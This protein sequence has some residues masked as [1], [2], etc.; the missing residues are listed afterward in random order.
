M[1]RMLAGDEDGGF[2]ADFTN[3]VGAV[4]D[5]KSRSTRSRPTSTAPA[6]EPALVASFGGEC[7]DRE[8]Y[9]VRPTVIQARR[10]CVPDDVRGDFWAGAH[11]A[12]VPGREVEGDAGPGGRHVSL[13][14]HRRRVRAGS[15]RGAR[16]GNGSALR[17]QA[18]SIST[19]SPPGPSW[20]SSP[21][22]ER[23][24]RVPTTRRGASSTWCAGCPREPSRR[25]SFPPK[26]TRIPSCRSL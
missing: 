8:G 25:T 11:P 19:T 18:T 15:W 20:G 1:G 16:S 26:T 21:S 13:R 4:I 17:C 3:F 12:R 14:A 23:G 24:A 22:G 7:D 9:F 10:S 5:R 6:R 2:P